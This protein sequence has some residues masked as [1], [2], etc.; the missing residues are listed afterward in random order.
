M[1]V[2]CMSCFG[3]PCHVQLSNQQS[4]LFSLEA[5]Q[6][7]E[8]LKASC[9]QDTSSSAVLDKTT[10]EWLRD[11]RLS[12]CVCVCGC[13]CVCVRV[14]GCVCVCVCVCGAL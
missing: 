1:S 5:R 11:G 12:V 7:P 4:N 10:D 9:F 8:S 2:Q 6:V 3:L 13:V 14:R